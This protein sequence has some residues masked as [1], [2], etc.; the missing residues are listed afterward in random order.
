MAVAVIRTITE[1]QCQSM[2]TW[3]PKSGHRCVTA[4]ERYTTVS[5][6]PPHVCTHICIQ[7]GNCG[8]INYN[9]DMRYCQLSSEACQRVVEDSDFTVT[10][11]CLHTWVQYANVVDD[12]RVSCGIS[13]SWFVA[14]LVFEAD[15]LVGKV[16]GNYAHV[17]KNGTIHSAKDPEVLQIRPWCSTKWIPYVPGDPIPA[18]A[19]VGGH[20]GNPPAQT[21]VINGEISGGRKSCGYYNPETKL[22][23]AVHGLTKEMDILVVQ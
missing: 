1:K 18:G 12:M 10:F 7:R 21:Y 14:R 13:N 20:V 6:V 16:S 5:N 8:V 17:R 2:K 3:D 22:G 9:D 19:V 11:Q 15:V 23:Y 4:S